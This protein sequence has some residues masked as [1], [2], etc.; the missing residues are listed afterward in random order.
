MGFDLDLTLVDSRPGIA[1]A[2]R[3]LAR[4]TGV[5]VDVDLV[6]SRIGPPLEQE[7]ANWFPATAVTAAAARYRE[8][9]GRLAV[10]GTTLLPGAADA[11]AAVHAA[12]ARVVVVSAKAV[13]GA[14]LV[15]DGVGLVVDEVVGGLFAAAKGT[16]LRRHGATVYVGDHVAD[17]L[18]A[19]AAEAVAVAVTTGT[20]S[21]AQL[22]AAGADVVLAD[23]TGFPD[24]YRSH[25]AV[26][27]A[28][29][30]GSPGPA[31]PSR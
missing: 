8:A 1:A 6:V 15:V 29:R 3:E 11:V 4:A 21:G 25:L 19:R 16:A 28:D 7:L 14:R 23:L 9:Y 17:V 5:A 24:W 30:S 20:S 22:R 18:A 12:G 13:A 31:D 26:R 27:A 10:A 2:M